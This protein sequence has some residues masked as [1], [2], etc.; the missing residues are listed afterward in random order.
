M[1]SG[2]TLC[3]FRALFDVKFR[4]AEQG[5]VDGPLECSVVLGM[6]A[7]EARMCGATSRSDSPL[8]RHGRLTAREALAR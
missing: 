7:A 1:G 4:G 3:K 8:D 2:A 6:V 5:N